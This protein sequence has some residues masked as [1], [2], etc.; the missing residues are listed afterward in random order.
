MN[1]SYWQK[2]ETL[3]YTAPDAV[4]AGAVVKLTGRIG[5]AAA[6]I[7]KGAR[8]SVH[9]VGV[10]EMPKAAAL[11]VTMGETVYYDTENDCI[12]TTATNNTHAGYAAALAS[13]NDASVLVK[14][15]G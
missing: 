8:G 2:G 7:E 1:A 12:T 14:L 9:M 15:L 5:V 10:F 11:A 6:A 4:Q 3:D 13:A